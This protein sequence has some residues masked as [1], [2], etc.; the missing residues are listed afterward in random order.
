MWHSCIVCLRA[1]IYFQGNLSDSQPVMI[2]D[3]IHDTVR[4]ALEQR[5]P[6]TNQPGFNCAYAFTDERSIPRQRIAQYS[7]VPGISMAG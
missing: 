2:F 5:Y 7:L 4:V 3:P 1:N 6:S